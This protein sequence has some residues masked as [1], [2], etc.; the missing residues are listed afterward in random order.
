M[1]VWLDRPTSGIRESDANCVRI[2]LVNNMPGA[3]L[4]NTE[5]QF[6]ALLDGAADGIEVR[7]SLLALPDIPRT[8][9]GRRHLDRFYLD[10]SEAEGSHLD[11]LIVTGTEPRT[12]SLR[13]E[14]Y[15]HSL[16]KLLEWAEERTYSSVWS[17]LAAHAAV[18]H[19]EGIVRRPLSEKRFGVFECARASD[20]MLTRGL[21]ARLNI[22]HS[23]WNEIAEE[24]LTASGYKVLTKSDDAGVDAFVKEAKSLFVFFQGHPEYDPDTLLL[25]YRRD[26]GRFLRGERETYPEMPCRYFDNDTVDAL[27]ALRERALSHRSEELLRELPAG[28][29]T[30]RAG[31]SWS[32]AATCIYRNWLQYLCSQKSTW[33]RGRRRRKHFTAVRAGAPQAIL[34][35]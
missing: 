21:P 28:I 32:G 33:L 31:N 35:I 9:A 1:P 15:W 16:T 12:P 6:R 26:V 14:P 23:R 11:G 4:E 30:V 5:R 18:L 13:D 17:C 19:R 2:G 24:S 8:D 7:L 20:H 27:A 22:P 3:A 25:E 10:V 29:E 34:Q